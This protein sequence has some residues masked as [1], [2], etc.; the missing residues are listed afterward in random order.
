MGEVSEVQLLIAEMREQQQLMRAFFAPQ[1][2]RQP[3]KRP[4]LIDSALGQQADTI[5]TRLYLNDPLNMNY[6]K[7][8]VDTIHNELSATYTILPD[9]KTII[10]NKVRNVRNPSHFASSFLIFITFS[11]LATSAARCTP[12]FP[13]WLALC[14]SK[15]EM[16]RAPSVFHCYSIIPSPKRSVDPSSI[17]PATMQARTSPRMASGSTPDWYISKQHSRAARKIESS[18]LTLKMTTPSPT[19]YT[20]LSKRNASR[21]RNSQILMEH[22]QG[23]SS[24]LPTEEELRS[25]QGFSFLQLFPPV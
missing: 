2:E 24:H 13:E 3:D 11:S 20:F 15:K 1:L 22:I 4:T 23:W 14:S 21:P 12:P 25:A 18:N 16:I 5:I 8:W 9:Q 10:S 6:K 7:N 19:R 17:K